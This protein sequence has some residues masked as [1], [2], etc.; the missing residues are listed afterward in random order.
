MNTP[1]SGTQPGPS[2][3]VARLEVAGDDT[4]SEGEVAV[5]CQDRGGNG[6]SDLPATHDSRVAID[7]RMTR[8]TYHTGETVS[9]SS[10]WL[11]NPSQRSREIEL[12]AWLAA[13]GFDPI[14]A[15]ALTPDGVLELPAAF[16][17][18]LG[19]LSLFDVSGDL[20]AGTYQLNARI[21]DPVTGD[22]LD[23]DIN[24][25]SVTADMETPRRSRQHARPADA[26]TQLAI[27]SHSAALE[28]S[29]ISNRRELVFANRGDA[30]ADVELKVWIE[31]P[32]KGPVSV[33]T[34][35]GNGSLLLPA[36]SALN[37]DPLALLQHSR[38]LP[39]GSYQLR[40]RI[41]DSVTGHVLSENIDDLVIR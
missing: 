1:I 26:K 6:V 14:S 19:P 36:G 12:K 4:E 25:F 35:G 11:S 34:L 8:G 5:G 24:P 10:S 23:E 31:G 28:S 16:D 20:P 40:S 9:T 2:L 21:L 18:D 7:I 13:P 38:K 15:G 39:A 30:P 33:F 41:L 37:L 3:S 22:T 17:E 32:E 27:G 29:G